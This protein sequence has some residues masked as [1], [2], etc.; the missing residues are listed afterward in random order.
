[1][2]HVFDPKKIECPIPYDKVFGQ[3]PD[4]VCGFIT[5][6]GSQLAESSHI[7]K[8][9]YSH[10]TEADVG[11]REGTRMHIIQ[12]SAGFAMSTLSMVPFLTSG[13]RTPR[14]GGV[15]K[16]RPTLTIC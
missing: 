14:T 13:A 2:A 10:Y 6:P 15:R 3:A 8:A 4:D 11:I 16:E 9:S 12:F 1:M 7:W 5:M